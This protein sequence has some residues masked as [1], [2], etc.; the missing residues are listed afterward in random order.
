M[1]SSM[2]CQGWGQLNSRI[3]SWAVAVAAL[4]NRPLV[5]LLWEGDAPACLPLTSKRSPGLQA[6]PGPGTQF[7]SWCWWLALL[8]IPI[9]PPSLALAP[10]L[11]QGS[12]S[13]LAASRPWVSSSTP[14][15]SGRCCP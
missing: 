7:R 11:V 2:G 3:H 15:A 10:A 14:G 1:P 12:S 6:S 8:S 5:S 9:P 13:R 4:P